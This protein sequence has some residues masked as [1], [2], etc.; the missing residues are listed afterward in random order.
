MGIQTEIGFIKL[1]TSFV[2][3]RREIFFV[4]EVEGASEEGTGRKGKAM[5]FVFN[6]HFLA[7][8][9][10]GGWIGFVFFL[11]GKCFL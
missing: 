10:F 8:F 11:S 3:L 9:G 6:Q 7:A 5:V 4:G 2:V 1:L